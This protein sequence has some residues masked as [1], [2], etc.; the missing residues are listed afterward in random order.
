MNKIAQLQQ[1][2]GETLIQLSKIACNLEHIPYSEIINTRL[3]YDGDECSGLMVLAK[4]NG[5][6]ESSIMRHYLLL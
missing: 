5:S 2:A 6:N 1:P 4:S 3:M